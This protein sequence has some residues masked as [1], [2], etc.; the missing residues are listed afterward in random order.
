MI[1]ICT[2]KPL[3]SIL[4]YSNNHGYC[5][6][7]CLD[8]IF[9]QTYDNIEVCLGD[10]ASTDDSWDIAVE[11]EKKYPGKMTIARNRKDAGGYAIFTSY[12]LNPR[13]KYLV[14]LNPEY[15]LSQKYVEKCI[16][17]LEANDQVAF[18]IVNSVAIDENGNYQ[19]NDPLYDISRA[20]SGE[21]FALKYMIF[22]ESIKISPAMYRVNTLNSRVSSLVNN[23]PMANLNDLK[24][25]FSSRWFTAHLLDFGMCISNTIFYICEPLI[26]NF[27]FSYESSEASDDLMDIV[28]PFL[29]QI[30]L[31]ETASYYDSMN[32]AADIL[33]ESLR[34]LSL[35]ALQKSYK[36][37]LNKKDQKALRYFHLSIAVDPN[38]LN[39]PLYKKMEKILEDSL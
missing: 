36:Y 31:A 35:C 34:E 9:A 19:K 15:V 13:G 2:D 1:K 28:S 32:E 27:K 23:L 18:C 22:E 14:D 30:Q 4:V 16:S 6:K 26:F 8:S 24:G 29:L 37:L 17:A 11:Y 12:L 25:G 7:R 39:D 21:E 38:I 3:V 20:I 10:N 33:Q 5:L